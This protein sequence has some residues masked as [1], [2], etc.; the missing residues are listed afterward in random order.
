MFRQLNVE[1]PHISVVSGPFTGTGTTLHSELIRE[2]QWLNTVKQIVVLDP[3]CSIPHAD[4]EWFSWSA[5]HAAQCKLPVTVS[6]TS[7]L[8]LFQDSSNIHS[9]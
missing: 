5:Y 2:Q 8:P 7:L 3:S 9:M 6:I 4:I 1:Q